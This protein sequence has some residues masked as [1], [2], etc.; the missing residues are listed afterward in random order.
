M[1]L[2]VAALLWMLT[3]KTAAQSSRTTQTIR[4]GQQTFGEYCASCHSTRGSSSLAA[5]GIRGFYSSHQPKPS[6]AAVRAIIARGKGKMPAFGN[7]S[8]VQIDE[9]IAYLKARY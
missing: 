4:H 6:D 8:H 9:L 5:P 7:L 2:L 3:V 1:L